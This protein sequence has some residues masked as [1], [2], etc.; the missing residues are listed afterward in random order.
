MLDWVLGSWRIHALQTGPK[1][2]V[3]ESQSARQ[4]E[5]GAMKRWRPFSMCCSLQRI[6][7]LGHKTTRLR[8]TVRRG[9]RRLTANLEGIR[10]PLSN[11]AFDG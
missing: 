7:F 9:R 8:L 5:S 1:Q 3:Q 4:P 6:L 2:E 10:V 11:R